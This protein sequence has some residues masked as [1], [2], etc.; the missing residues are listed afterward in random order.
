MAKTLGPE[1]RLWVKAA[2]G[3]TYGMLKGETTLKFSEQS[4][5]VP[6]GTKDDWPDDPELPGAR[7]ITITVEAIP[8][9]PD[10]TGYTRLETVAASRLPVSIQLRSGGMT[11]ADP[12]DVVFEAPMNV[13]NRDTDMNRGE[14][15]KASFTLT[16]AGAVVTNAL[17]W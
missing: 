14:A 10:A 1:I 13:L 3:E 12:D 6:V 2:S 7:K 15:V 9:L 5:G 4:T 11:G 17:S 16:L 8:D